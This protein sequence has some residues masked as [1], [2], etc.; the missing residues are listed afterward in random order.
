MY[1]GECITR[2]TWVG[3]NLTVAG[4]NAISNHDLDINV[5]PKFYFISLIYVGDRITWVGHNLTV[6]G[7]NVISNHD[8]DININPKFYFHILLSLRSVCLRF[9]TM[10]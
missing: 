4:F 6:A 9:D 2:I 5:N 10:S 3:H 7:F 1:D 8:L